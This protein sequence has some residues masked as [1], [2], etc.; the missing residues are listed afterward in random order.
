MVDKVERLVINSQDRRENSLILTFSSQRDT[1]SNFSVKLRK[2][3]HAFA[4][5]IK[6]VI[7]PYLWYPVSSQKENT[8]F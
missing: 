4:Y 8:T 3:L 2:P 6:K 1:G 5:A 7:I